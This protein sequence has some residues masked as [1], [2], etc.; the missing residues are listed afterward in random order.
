[1]NDLNLI[2]TT[3]PIRKSSGWDRLKNESLSRTRR[4]VEPELQEQ[5]K[6][7]TG[8]QRKTD[9][10]SNRHEVHIFD[11]EEKPKNQ[12]IK[13]ENTKNRSSMFNSVVFK[14]KIA[15]DQELTPKERNND[16]ALH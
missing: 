9:A 14:Q 1:M 6:N 5:S 2:K 12:V 10:K 15:N 3:N 11:V 7:L 4:I 16:N 8:C 13:R